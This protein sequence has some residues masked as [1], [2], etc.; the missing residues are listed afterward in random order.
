MLPQAEVHVV[1]LQHTKNAYHDLM[2]GRYQYLNEFMDEMQEAPEL[3]KYIAL[4]FAGFSWPV[5]SFV[6]N[7]IASR[8]CI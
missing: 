4:P 3:E 1:L 7:D 6:Q 2:R 8:S 5:C